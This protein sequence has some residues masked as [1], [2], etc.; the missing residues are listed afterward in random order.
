MKSDNKLMHQNFFVALHL[1]SPVW[2]DPEKSGREQKPE[3]TF[4]WALQN[5]DT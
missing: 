1:K 2:S 4:L 5:N 3:F